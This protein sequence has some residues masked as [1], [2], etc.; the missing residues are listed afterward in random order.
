MPVREEFIVPGGIHVVET[1]RKIVRAIQSCFVIQ[2]LP[3]DLVHF[4]AK[5]LNIGSDLFGSLNCMLDFET[6]TKEVEIWSEAEVHV[7]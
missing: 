7:A 6:R 5:E 3:S 2:S 4:R 1:L